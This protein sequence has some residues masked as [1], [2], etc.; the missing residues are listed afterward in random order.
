MKKITIPAEAAKITIST[1]DVDYQFSRWVDDLINSTQEFGKGVKVLRQ[2][3]ELARIV[4]D[5]DKSDK[6]FLLEEEHYKLLSKA[7]NTP[8]NVIFGR[9]AEAAGYYSAVEN[10]EDFKP[11]IK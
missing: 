3:N 6:V 1:G 7:I 9:R 2:V 5:A 11:E 10:A 4:E 8:L